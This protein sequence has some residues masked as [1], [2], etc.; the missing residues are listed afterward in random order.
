M[1]QRILDFGP[2]VEVLRAHNDSHVLVEA[3]HHACLA[4]PTPH[5][6]FPQIAPQFRDIVGHVADDRAV[7]EEE[8]AVRLARPAVC[9]A[10]SCVCVFPVLLL[11][12]RGH[13]TCGHALP[14]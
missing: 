8:V 13:S 5:I 7:F 1:R 9:G 12:Q 6:V 11:A 10:V 14:I 4:R 2:T 3:A